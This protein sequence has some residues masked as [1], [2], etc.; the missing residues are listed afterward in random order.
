M[1]VAAWQPALGSQVSAPLQ[2]RPSSHSPLLAMLSHRSADSL[3]ESSVQLTP[4]LQLG[5]VLAVQTATPVLESQVS[6]PLQNRPSSQTI[7][8]QG[9][10]CRVIGSQS[11]LEPVPA[12][13]RSVH[14][15]L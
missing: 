15:F 8:E 9:S 4:S 3:H 10:T 1:G 2:N 12:E 5:A 7:S 11:H 13:A 14:A 6:T